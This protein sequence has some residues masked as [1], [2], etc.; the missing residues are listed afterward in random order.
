MNNSWLITVRDSFRDPCVRPSPVSLLRPWLILRL[1][2]DL[3]PLVVRHEGPL[4]SHAL[5]TF[6]SC[7]VTFL[8]SPVGV[9]PESFLGVK[10]VLGVYPCL[11]SLD[12]GDTETG[13]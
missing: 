7:S 11:S 4:L 6:R 9:T 3:P 2:S 12:P 5:H 13:G 1:S 8:L 10:R